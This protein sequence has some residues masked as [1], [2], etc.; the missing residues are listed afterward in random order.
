MLIVKCNIGL[1]T[2]V[3][4]CIS[5]PVVFGDLV[6]KFKIIIGKEER[7]QR[8]NQALHLT[9]DTN[10]KVTTS[11]LDIT[12]ESQ[13]VSPFPAGGHNLSDQFKKIIKRYKAIVCIPGRKPNHGL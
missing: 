6:Y 2:P 3:Q 13:E 5:E 12:N 7:G 4:L 8:Y 9:Q 11:Q 1:N 10:G